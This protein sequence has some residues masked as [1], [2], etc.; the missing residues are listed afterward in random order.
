MS[1][2]SR[3]SDGGFSPRFIVSRTDGKV[4]RDSAR[5]MVLDGSGADPH[6]LKALRVYA[7]SVRTDNE[8]LAND[9]LK[10][11]NGNWPVE[12]AQHNNAK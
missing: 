5:Y 12:F 3:F 4:C 9:L 6:A 1:Q 7:E 8:E 2:N 10:M 11:L